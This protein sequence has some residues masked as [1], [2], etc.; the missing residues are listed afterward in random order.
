MKI[1]NRDLPYD[2]VLAIPREP[3]LPPKRPTMLFRTL[4]KTL[5]A[6]ELRAVDFSYTSKGMERVRTGRHDQ[7]RELKHA[8]LLLPQDSGRRCGKDASCGGGAV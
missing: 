7:H 5:S 4:L 3:H 6:R 8:L 2:E 1:K